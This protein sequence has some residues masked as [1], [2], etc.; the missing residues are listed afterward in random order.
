MA[1]HLQIYSDADPYPDPAYHFDAGPDPAYHFDSD[2]D[3]DPDPNFQSDKDQDQQHCLSPSGFTDPSERSVS[4]SLVFLK[5][6]F[7]P[8]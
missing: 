1:C 8:I 5:C 3:V 7:V 4:S 6:L 2:P